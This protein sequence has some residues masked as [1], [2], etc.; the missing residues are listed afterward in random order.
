MLAPWP[1]F[2]SLQAGQSTLATASSSAYSTSEVAFQL[3][4]PAR[5]IFDGVLLD[6]AHGL[7]RGRTAVNAARGEDFGLLPL[8][9]IELV[10]HP[11]GG[12]AQRGA[13]FAGGPNIHQAMHHVL[14]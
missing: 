5:Q 8:Q 7:E 12:K 14:L 13:G 1:V 9:R 11:R 6:L 2:Q 3:G 4:P 10:E